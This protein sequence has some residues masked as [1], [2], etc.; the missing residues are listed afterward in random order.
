MRIIDTL[1]KHLKGES[2]KTIVDNVKKIKT[3]LKKYRVDGLK[4]SG[5]LGLENLVFKVLR[6]NGYIQKLY[7]EPIKFIDTKLS[8]KEAELS[9][10]LENTI[11][12]AKFGVV[13]PGLDKKKP[14]SGVDLKA[15]TGTPIYSP[16]NGLV[17]K[18]DMVG[19]NGGCGGTLYI[20]HKNGFE[21][22]FCHCSDI[23]V[24]N[25]DSVK[26]GQKVGLTGG[27][28]NDRGRGFSTGAHLHY[29]LVKDGVLV[30][31]MNFIGSFTPMKTITKMTTSVDGTIKK[32]M[33][34]LKKPEYQ[35]IELSKLKEK[36]KDIKILEDLTKII[37]QKN[38]FKFFRNN[39]FNEDVVL[40]Q[41]ILKVL[42]YSDEEFK[43]NGIYD[44]N[45]QEIVKEFQNDNNLD[46][47][48]IINTEDL[49]VLYFLVLAN[50]LQQSEFEKI[51]IDKVDE[52]SI[53]DLLVYQEIL[54]NL[55]APISKENLRF[56][57]ALRNSFTDTKAKN[58]PFNVKFNLVDDPKMSNYNNTNTKNYSSPE[59]GIKATI[60]T[61]KQPRYKCIVDSLKIQESAEVIARCEILQ[62]IGIQDEILDLLKN[63]NLIPVKIS[64]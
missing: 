56:L 28:K 35:D 42:G 49:K 16:D 52:F 36:K 9:S 37:N 47:N 54:T 57:Y 22:R 44:L 18:S 7:S 20:K 11:V 25:G 59:Y 30:D 48:G 27:G 63:E 58:N 8:L 61:L 24:K 13:R 14:H 51:K 1:L 64:N 23:L 6:R 50:E 12:G 40:I 34:I 39:S 3:K 53:P 46:P 38:Q 15:S 62:S 31:P 33:D 60:K 10:P 55:G 41:K 5:E 21:S 29:T 19:D 32:I 17:V 26:K 45:T 2:P 4:G 43:I